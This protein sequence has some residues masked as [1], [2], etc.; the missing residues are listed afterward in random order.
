MINVRLNLIRL[1]NN[2]NLVV[3]IY[4]VSGCVFVLMKDKESQ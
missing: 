4:L 1:Y 3:T 2:K